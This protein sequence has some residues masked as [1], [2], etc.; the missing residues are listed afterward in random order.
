MP[1]HRNA[2]SF[3][4]GDPRAAA[5][6]RKGGRQRSLSALTS[7]YKVGYQ[8][9]A[10]NARRHIHRW[11]QDRHME[12]LASSP[13]MR[14][15]LRLHKD[16]RAATTPDARRAA[17]ESLAHLL[18]MTGANRFDEWL[19][20]HPEPDYGEYVDDSMSANPEDGF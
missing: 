18:R 11:I 12:S 9:G 3:L 5:A 16:Q 7:D 4:P 13:F 15:A 6:G 14:A 20:S 10:R 8:A 2:Q 17:D 19:A 1:Q